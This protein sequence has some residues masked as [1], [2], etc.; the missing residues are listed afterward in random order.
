[1][2]AFSL[3]AVTVR[4][5]NRVVLN[6]VSFRARPGAVTAI[7]GPSGSGKTTLLH[8]LGG[9]LRPTAGVAA[10]DLAASGRIAW[11]VQNSPLLPRRTCQENVALGAVAT[12]K[13]WDESQRVAAAMLGELGLE[14]TASTLGFRLSGGEKQR[15]A[16]ARAM[17]ADASVVL[18]DEPTASLDSDSRNLVCLALQRAARR[19]SSVIVTTHDD[20]VAGTASQVLDLRGGQLTETESSLRGHGSS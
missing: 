12:G 4:L 7:T 11:I 6:E 10:V 17:A 15:M 20:F 8:V 3:S 5:G 18:A 13:E 1:M 19:G 9:L 16:V 14:H 2:R